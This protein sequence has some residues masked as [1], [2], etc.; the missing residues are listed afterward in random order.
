MTSNSRSR[1]DADALV[2]ELRTPLAV[3][4]G[5]AELLA[6]RDDDETRREAAAG[7]SKAAARLETLVDELAERAAGHDRGAEPERD[8]QASEAGS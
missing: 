5:Y 4:A 6:T 7:I 2:H 1:E 8:G 3:I